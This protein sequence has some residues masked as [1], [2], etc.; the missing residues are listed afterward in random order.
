MEWWNSRKKLR[1]SSLPLIP[2]LLSRICSGRLLTSNAHFLVFP[3]DWFVSLTVHL[4]NDIT[5]AEVG[6]VTLKSNGDEA[7]I[8]E[9]L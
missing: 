7:L 8:D 4:S 9:S 3:G 5:Y 1:L 2:L 6:K